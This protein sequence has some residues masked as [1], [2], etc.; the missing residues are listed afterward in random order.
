VIHVPQ[1]AWLLA[2]SLTFLALG[3]ALIFLALPRVLLWSAI[4]VLSLAAAVAAVEWPSVLPAVVYGCEP[5]GLV[6]VVVLGFH[7]MLQRRYRRQVVFLPGFTRL[8]PGSSL[9]RHGNA[10]RPRGEP[11]TVDVPAQPAVGVREPPS[12]SRRQQAEGGTQ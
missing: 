11:S 6:L 3:M 10:L 4:V 12:E 8:K 9:V 7:W 1:Q 2:C 5:G